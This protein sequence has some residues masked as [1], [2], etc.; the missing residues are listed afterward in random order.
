MSTKAD[1]VQKA[2][3]GAALTLE[4]TFELFPSKPRVGDAPSVEADV[5]VTEA[6]TS[7]IASQSEDLDAEA[8][9]FSKE[10]GSSGWIRTSNPPVNS[11]MLYR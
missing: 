6:V 10:F 2:M 3:D 1:Q 9:E 7:H 4:P 8:A 11:R 5:T